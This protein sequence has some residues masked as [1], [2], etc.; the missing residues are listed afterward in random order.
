M[1]EL[2][3]ISEIQRLSLGPNDVVVLRV[4]RDI[5][6]KQAADLKSEWLKA[7]GLDHRVIVLAGGITVELLEETPAS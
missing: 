2:P 7:T 3:P 1:T 5:T 4:D 6:P